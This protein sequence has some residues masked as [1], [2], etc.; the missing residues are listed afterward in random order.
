MK[1]LDLF[2]AGLAPRY[3][4]RR[5]QARA[6]VLARYESATSTHRRKATRSVGSADRVNQS[7]IVS[8]R[9]QA[10][11]FE[12]NY[13]I[14]SGILDVLVNN[15]VGMG[16]RPDPQIKDTDGNLLDDLNKQ[17]RVLHRDWAKK[18]EVTHE[19]DYYT[20]Q[21]LAARSMY[22][23][24]EMLTQ[25]LTGTI[26]GLT[27]GTVVPFSLELLEADFL[28]MDL[29][30]P[31][32]GITQGVQKN[33]WGRPTWYHVYKAHPGGDMAIGAKT[34]RIKA[35]SILHP[36]MVKRIGQT[37]GVS[38][39]ATVLGRFEDIKEI[40]ESERV[41]ARVAAAMTGYIKKGSPDL[42]S[43]PAP[44]DDLRMMDFEPG[45]IFDDLR[46]GEEIGVISSNRPNLKVTEFRDDNMR[47]AAC[48][49]GTSASSIMKKYD[50]SYS[51]QRQELVE[52]Y[53]QYGPLWQYFVRTVCHPTWEAFVEAAFLSGAIEAPKNIDRAT[54]FDVDHS[55]PAMPW[56]DPKKEADGIEKRLSL[57]LMARSQAI[58][59][60]GGD[61][62]EV[63][64]LIKR[65]AAEDEVDGYSPAGL[66]G[67]PGSM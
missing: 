12:E 1:A 59:Q 9:D 31:S 20:A 56:I 37:R 62:D 32:K 11:F 5:M 46:E 27:H 60:S 14:A 19:F 22:R 30:D 63:R 28:P 47:A 35:S 24:G 43:A 7:A 4:L 39:F 36:K 48:G 10:R 15:T 49:V 41:A 21:R 45:L 18:P 53:T 6:A 38:V 17:L 42:Y 29:T 67:S 40:E 26:R 8:L 50:G 44:G 55:R 61:P 64:D 54:R 16:I 23:D 66:G 52:S 65:E 3:A 58:R 25:L 2:L 57:R 33:Q 13:D 34:K 51:S